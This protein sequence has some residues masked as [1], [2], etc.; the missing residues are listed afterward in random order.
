MK[1]SKQLES[2]EYEDCDYSLTF[3]ERKLHHNGQSFLLELGSAFLNFPI[4]FDLH[5]LFN[6]LT[7]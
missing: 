4:A 1:A 3:V 6:I 2:H 5:K 7:V